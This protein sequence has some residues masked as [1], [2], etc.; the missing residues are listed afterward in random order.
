MTRPVSSEMSFALFGQDLQVRLNGFLQCLKGL[1]PLVP[2]AK[3]IREERALLLRIPLPLLDVR[4]PCI[5]S[6]FLSLQPAKTPGAHG[7]K[8]YAQGTRCIRGR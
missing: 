5:L 6:N 1:L 8:I 3:S 2:P 4:G 7:E